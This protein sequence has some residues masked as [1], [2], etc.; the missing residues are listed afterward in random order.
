MAFSGK[1]RLNVLT[2]VAIMIF[3]VVLLKA[4]N[5]IADALIETQRSVS[6]LQDRLTRLEADQFH[7]QQMH[8]ECG[9]SRGELPFRMNR[10]APNQT[11]VGQCDVCALPVPVPAASVH[12]TYPW[13]SGA[14][15]PVAWNFIVHP[16]DKDR[17]VSASF[18]QN[19]GMN[20]FESEIKELFY[21]LLSGHGKMAMLSGLPRAIDPLVVDVGANIGAYFMRT[22]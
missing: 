3:S 1:R 16:P 18:L 13:I 20:G 2:V 12:L 11:R 6:T 10:T 9:Y 19:G 15:S 21:Q 17:I 14:D 5:L 7:R 22:D 8:I 4:Y